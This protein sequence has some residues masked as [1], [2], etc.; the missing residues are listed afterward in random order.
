VRHNDANETVFC[1]PANES[2]TLA[3]LTDRASRT[4]TRLEPLGD[5]VTIRL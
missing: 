5:Q 3:R 2:K 4:G 1:A